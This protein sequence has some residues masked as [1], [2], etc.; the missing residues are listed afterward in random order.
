MEGDYTKIN[1][2]REKFSKREYIF[3]SRQVFRW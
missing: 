3:K 1:F 2:S